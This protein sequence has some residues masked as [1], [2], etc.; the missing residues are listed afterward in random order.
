M[1]VI[2]W[3]ILV[4]NSRLKLFLLKDYVNVRLNGMA[5]DNIAVKP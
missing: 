2:T 3:P 4:I 1:T 5:Y